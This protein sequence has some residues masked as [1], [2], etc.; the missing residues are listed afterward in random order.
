M[1]LIKQAFSISNA[2]KEEAKRHYEES[3]RELVQKD[4]VHECSDA[5]TELSAIFGVRWLVAH[6]ENGQIFFTAKQYAAANVA[7]NYANCVLGN[8]GKFLETVRRVCKPEE[9]VSEIELRRMNK[10][11]NSLL[12]F[13]TPALLQTVL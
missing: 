3:V 8:S 11:M 5:H 7:F 9:C 12:T 4:C 10:A 6:K 2:D 1:D 13:T